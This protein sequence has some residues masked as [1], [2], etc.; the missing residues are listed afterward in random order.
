[1]SLRSINLTKESITYEKEIQTDWDNIHSINS[2]SQ[3]KSSTEI[4][5]QTDLD[6]TK[7]EKVPEPIIE[8]QHEEKEQILKSEL[9]RDFFDRSST[10]IERVLSENYDVLT[11]YTQMVGE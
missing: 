3:I 5:I 10:V 9:F 4:Q 11:D 6:K 7:P 1:L 8:L 2:D